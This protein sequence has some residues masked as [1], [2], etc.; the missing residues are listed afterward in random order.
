MIRKFALI[1]AML[2]LS[3]AAG[4]APFP[5]AGP[6][7]AVRGFGQTLRRYKGKDTGFPAGGFAADPTLVYLGYCEWATCGPL[8]AAP[9]T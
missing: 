2:S 1:L 6:N 7:A 3:A 9:R 4:C 5:C 8:C